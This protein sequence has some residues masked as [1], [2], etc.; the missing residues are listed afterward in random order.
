MRTFNFTLLA[1]FGYIAMINATP[2]RAEVIGR[3]DGLYVA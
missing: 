2:L 1:L 3:R